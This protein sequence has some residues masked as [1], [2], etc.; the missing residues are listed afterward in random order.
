MYACGSDNFAY[1]G[2][3]TLSKYRR[4]NAQIESRDWPTAYILRF[5]S[6]IAFYKNYVL[7]HETAIWCCYSVYQTLNPSLVKIRQHAP[8]HNYLINKT[9]WL[10]VHIWYFEYL[11]MHDN[12]NTIFWFKNIVLLLYHTLYDIVFLEWSVIYCIY[13]YIPRGRKGRKC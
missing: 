2:Y 1:L 12:K 11:H 10:W 5:P 9:T 3:I 7:P 6:L 13:V 8:L 4:C